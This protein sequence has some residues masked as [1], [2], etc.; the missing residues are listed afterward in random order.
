MAAKEYRPIHIFRLVDRLKKDF[1][2]R[3]LKAYTEL[4]MFED[5]VRLFEQGA[6]LV[7]TRYEKDAVC[8]PISTKLHLIGTRPGQNNYRRPI[9]FIEVK[10]LVIKPFGELA[11]KDA[12]NEGLADL[13][14][15]R[16][17]LQKIY[18]PIKDPELVSIFYLK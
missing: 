3:R 12:K 7:T 13:K 1:P 16:S 6:K 2:D 11:D 10:R 5:F 14:E 4:K 8:Y 9:G 18:G 17:V 15:M